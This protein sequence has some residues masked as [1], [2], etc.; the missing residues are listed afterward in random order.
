MVRE[1][2]NRYLYALIKNHGSDLH[3][4]AGS[5]IRVRIHGILHKVE[6]PKLTREG[7]INL[8]KELLRSRFNELVEKKEIDFSYKLDENYRFRV[9]AFFQVDGPSIVFRVIPIKI[10]TIEELGLPKVVKKFA[11]ME[12][13]LVLVTGVKG[14]GKSTTLAAL[15]NEINEKKPKHIIT[16]EDPVEF[17][18][19]EKKALINQR[20][21]GEDT[22]SFSSALRAALREDPDIILVGEMRDKETMEIALHAAETGHLVFSTLHT[23]DAKETLNR[24]IGIFP[25]DEQPRIR[26]V[27]ASVLEG[28]ISQR[29]VPT[30]DRKRVA[31]MEIMLKTARIKELILQNRDQEIKDAIEEGKKVYGT[32]SFDQHLVD[33]V[34][35]GKVSEE[36]AIEF[37]TSPDDFLLKLKKE[38]FQKG[39]AGTDEDVIS[40]KGDGD[41]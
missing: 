40:L 1:E 8:L 7:V 10:P 3:V 13:G 25:P 2:L 21:L 36:R 19:K 4:K 29:L 41:K 39:I 24:I 18:H 5:G 26:L 15:I 17:I 37:A 16:I 14:S 22:L 32:Q 31:A 6:S 30:V 9:N 27:L 33:L 11:M 35:E 20:S 12:R 28:I 38:K 23:L 34:L